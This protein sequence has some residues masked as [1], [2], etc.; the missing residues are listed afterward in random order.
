M[1]ELRSKLEV[2][3]ASAE[4][5]DTLD[6]DPSGSSRLMDLEDSEDS[7]I[8][9]ASINGLQSSDEST[10]HTG[11]MASMVQSLT[12]AN[13][14]DAWNEDPSQD[15]DEYNYTISDVEKE[16][17]LQ[18]M[19]PD[20]KV[21]DIQLAMRRSDSFDSVVDDLLNQCFLDFGFGSERG[22]SLIPRGIDGFLVENDSESN[23]SKRKGRKRNKVHSSVGG[24]ES[25][26]ATTAPVVTKNHWDRASN[27]VEFI[28]SRTRLSAGIVQSAYHA[29]HA[30]LAETILS[31]CQTHTHTNQSIVAGSLSN[32]TNAGYL[33]AE[34]PKL[35]FTTIYAIIQLTAPSV[36]AA[37]DLANIVASNPTPPSPFTNF[38]P[39]TAPS[40]LVTSN[41]LTV[42]TA[43]NSNPS[44]NQSPRGQSLQV[45]CPRN[46][47]AR[48]ESPN[49]S[50]SALRTKHAVTLAAVSAA[51]RR[52]RSHPHHRAVAGHYASL[53][54]EAG[55]RARQHASALADAHVAR[56]STSRELDL[57]GVGVADAV[58]M[59]SERAWSWWNG[60]AAEWARNGKAG[61]G[62]GGGGLGESLRVV[63]GKGKHSVGGKAKLG[64]AVQKAL[65]AEGWRVEVEEA[66][67]VVVGR[68]RQE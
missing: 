65:C 27:D 66:V 28:T 61:W 47:S 45:Q 21:L 25:S 67:L 30:S 18:V 39:A 16:E 13:M 58:R 60:G 10:T 14:E 24:S 7:Q 52:A 17:L 44:R 19:F 53:A 54:T 32:A 29:S 49:T 63:V 56:Q 3:K 68:K 40:T 57:H 64:P 15:D 41:P 20:V 46:Q 42:V 23:T 11:D 38:R 6:F 22:E 34:F 5:E 48:A 4:S 35:S 55:H 12:S 26:I 8:P 59:A 51:Y 62:A 36:D 31:L 2:I 33:A 37:S 1:Q 50:Y 9:S 43:R